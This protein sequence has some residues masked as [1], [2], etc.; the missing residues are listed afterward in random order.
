MV[1]GSR[2][3][4]VLPK[5]STKVL[6]AVVLGV[7]PLEFENRRVIFLLRAYSVRPG[8]VEVKTTTPILTLCDGEL[9]ADA[10]QRRHGLGAEEKRRSVR[11]LGGVVVVVLVVAFQNGSRPPI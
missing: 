8:A 7:V 1:G 5:K 4:T 11:V 10:R 9:F 6:V 2:F 3:H